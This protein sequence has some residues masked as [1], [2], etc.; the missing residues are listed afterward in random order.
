MLIAISSRRYRILWHDDWY[1]VPLN[2]VCAD[3]RGGRYWFAWC[4]EPFDDPWYG[5]GIWRLGHRDV[6]RV[7]KVPV[8]FLLTE[9]SSTRLFRDLVGGDC[10][11]DFKSRRVHSKPGAH[12]T[13]ESAQR[14][15]DRPKTW[16]ERRRTAW[17]DW[18]LV[19]GGTYTTFH[20]KP[21][22]NAIRLAAEHPCPRGEAKVLRR[23]RGS[24]PPERLFPH[25]W[26]VR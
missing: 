9:Q 12:V 14:F 20:R 11:H 4:R 21:A 17:G 5:N 22:T 19:K 24:P 18:G 16:A 8:G 26:S 25:A 2:G 10:F 7:C 1:D 3:S 13:A 6:Y 15:Y 23:M